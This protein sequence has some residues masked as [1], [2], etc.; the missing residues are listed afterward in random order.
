MYVE[1]ISRIPRQGGF[2]CGRNSLIDK[3][4]NWIIGR[5]VEILAVLLKYRVLFK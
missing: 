1:T 5:D 2:V 4:S 3:K